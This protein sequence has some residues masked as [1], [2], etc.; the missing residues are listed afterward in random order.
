LSETQRSEIKVRSEGEVEMF[1]IKKNVTMPAP[2][3][4]TYPF[5]DM[6]LGDMFFVP[7]MNEDNIDGTR[8]KLSSAASMA[9]KRLGRKFST[10]VISE[11]GQLGVG[12]WRTE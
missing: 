12:V 7:E 9:S 4:S 10:Q 3:R 8:K 5:Q 6:G 2:Q 11:D 1:K